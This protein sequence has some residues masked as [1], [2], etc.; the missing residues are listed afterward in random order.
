MLSFL[1]AILLCAF[2]AEQP[3]ADSLYGTAIPVY[4]DTATIQI[5]TDDFSSIRMSDEEMRTTIMRI[6]RY[7]SPEKSMLNDPLFAPGEQFY[8]L[9]NTPRNPQMT[10]ELLAEKLI[11]EQMARELNDGKKAAA[12]GTVF[13]VLQWLLILL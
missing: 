7:G 9:F 5:S 12:A 13:W 1:S 6:V 11:R 4:A 3:P 2:P 8:G 10:D